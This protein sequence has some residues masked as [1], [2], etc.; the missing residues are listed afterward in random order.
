[1]GR[2]GRGR[3][4]RARRSPATERAHRPLHS[5]QSKRNAAV[6]DAIRR[7][8]GVGT[9]RDL[10]LRF[11]KADPA[12]GS[13]STLDEAL[14]NSLSRLRSKGLIGRTADSYSLVGAGSEIGRG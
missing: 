6:L 13:P 7:I 11:P 1:V 9:I 14:R 12:A 2:R 10:R 8:G 5:H 4:R 3:R